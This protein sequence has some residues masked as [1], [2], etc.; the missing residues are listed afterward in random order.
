ME[1][2]RFW[3]NTLNSL[4]VQRLPGETFKFWVNLLCL[5]SQ[6][7]TKGSVP[8]RDEI[9]FA[10]R[11]KNDKV[12]VHINLLIEAGLLEDMG[13]GG[14]MI[15]DWEE[16]QPQGD[17]PAERMRRY[18]ERKRNVSSNGSVAQPLRN[19]KRNARRNSD[20]IDKDTDTDTDT[21][22]EKDD[23]PLPPSRGNVVV[24]SSI[25]DEP[26]EFPDALTTI[27][28]VQSGEHSFSEHE[29]R[30]IWGHLWRTWKDTRLCYGFYEKQRW[31]SVQGWLYAIEMTLKQNVRPGSI[32]YLQKIGMDF[33]ING[34]KR[35]KPLT[36]GDIGPVPYKPTNLAEDGSTKIYPIIREGT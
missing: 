4:K 22:T 29:A 21:E 14:L 28:T 15:H 18:R 16:W 9:E 32:K 6:G 27:V 30:K 5:V 7:D 1:W 3:N 8:D 19:A 10:L 11:V 2:F 17:D 12:S 20:V 26:P 25:E 34:P 24:S 33:D 36:K 13:E 23:N 31:C 35:E